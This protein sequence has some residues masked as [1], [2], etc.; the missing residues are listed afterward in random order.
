MTRAVVHLQRKNQVRGALVPNLLLEPESQGQIH[1]SVGTQRGFEEYHA[2]E[3]RPRE[4][5]AWRFR[6]G[7]CELRPGL[8]ATDVKRY[9]T[10]LL[11]L[12]P[13]ALPGHL[14]TKLSRSAIY[15]DPPAW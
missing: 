9:L 12:F 8:S 5:G 2:P 7:V 15:P 1:A 13:N 11:P 4:G 6:R 10:L 14:S 3:L